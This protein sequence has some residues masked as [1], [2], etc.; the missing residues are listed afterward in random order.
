MQLYRGGIA[1]ASVPSGL[2]DFHLT[3]YFNFHSNSQVKLLP[4]P[5]LIGICR[6]W[7]PTIPPTPLLILPLPLPLDLPLFLRHTT[8]VSQ[9]MEGVNARLLSRQLILLNRTQMRKRWYTLYAQDILLHKV[10]SPSTGHVRHLT[11]R[12]SEITHLLPLWYYRRVWSNEHQESCECECEG[13]QI[14]SFRFKSS[15]RRPTMFFS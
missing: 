12:R 1:T 9:I 7:G 6:H 10:S 3:L 13:E 2:S 4:I 11:A 5:D 8:T 15:H 14:Y